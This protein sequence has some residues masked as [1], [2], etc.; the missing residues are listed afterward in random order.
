MEKLNHY[1]LTTPA[2]VY[3][4]EAMTALELAGRTAG[5]VNEIIDEVNKLPEHIEN[6]VDA[7]IDR[8]IN[9]G[10]FDEAIDKYSGD[11]R[12][13]IEAVDQRVNNIFT[14]VPVGGTTMDAELVDIR[15]THK[16]EVEKSAGDAVRKSFKGIETVMSSL[17]SGNLFDFSKASVG[18]LNSSNGSSVTRE[19]GQNNAINSDFIAVKPGE[20]YSAQLLIPN[21][22][23]DSSSH[24]VVCFY[25]AYKNFLTGLSF[26]DVDFTND[27]HEVFVVPSGASFMR[28]S[29]RQFMDG[30]FLLVKGSVKVG[31]DAPVFRTDDNIIEHIPN[32]GGYYGD[33]GRLVNQTANMEFATPSVPV[34]PGQALTV[35]YQSSNPYLNILY[36]DVANRPVG[37]MTRFYSDIRTVITIPEGCYNVAFSFRRPAGAFVGVYRNADN[38]RAMIYDLARAGK[39]F[40]D[41]VTVVAHGGGSIYAPENTMPCFQTYIDRGFK[42]LE[43]DIRFTSDNIPVCLHDSSI[44]RTARKKDGSDVSDTVYVNANTYTVLNDT[45]DFGIWWGSS[46]AETPMPKVEDF[47][48][49]CRKNACHAFLEV[50]TGNDGQIEILV[51]L[52]NKLG[53]LRDVTWM[54]FNDDILKKILKIDPYAHVGYISNSFGVNDIDVVVGLPTL[55]RPFLNTGDFMGETEDRD[56]AITYANKNGI[57]IGFWTVDDAEIIDMLHDD[58]NIPFKMLTT[59]KDHVKRVGR[60]YTDDQINY[61]TMSFEFEIGMNWIE[62]CDSKYN[63]YG[64]SYNEDTETIFADIDSGYCLNNP[65]NSY[66]HGSDIIEDGTIYIINW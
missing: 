11:L 41:G 18:M 49:L 14:G 31:N 27:V 30:R 3:D 19:N 58:T 51:E 45:Y 56:K 52:V 64:F 53:M 17:R 46:F 15:L 22:P 63:T 16:G 39:T 21:N 40:P 50:K 57:D 4:E 2:S 48:K 6:T 42:A 1:S 35:V 59:N 36:L 54:S 24:I 32:Y 26:W 28:V 8:K 23:T 47:L 65:D 20:E 43:C 66:V 29:Y 7:N 9:N 10:A 34:T 44:N 12:D 13:Y 37:T 33:D 60:F 55:T 61:G 5:K 62:F 25:N 38:V